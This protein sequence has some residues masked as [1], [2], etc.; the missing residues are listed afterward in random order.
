MPDNAEAPVSPTTQKLTEISE[1][2][3]AAIYAGIDI[4]L[5]DGN[6][7][8]FSLTQ[9]DQINITNAA[10][11]IL[12]GAASFPYHADGQLC[13]TFTAE[14]INI[15]AEAATQHV[16]YHTTYC[17]HLNYWIKRTETADELAAISYGAA[18]PEDLSANMAAVLA[19]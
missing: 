18:L 15:L 4:T 11:A 19:G 1:A 3:R 16:I 14:E 10:A 9:E 7:Y 12:N 6:T 5:P 17:N 8:H 2:C 13:R